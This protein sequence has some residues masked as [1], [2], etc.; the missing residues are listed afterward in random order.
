MVS[1]CFYA[2]LNKIY[3]RHVTARN[4]WV[5]HLLCVISHTKLL[6][7]CLGRDHL[8]ESVGAGHLPLTV[9]LNNLRASSFEVSSAL[10]FLFNSC[11]KTSQYSGLTYKWYRTNLR[12]LWK[13]LW[14]IIPP[15]YPNLKSVRELIYK[16]GHGRMRKQRI[17]LTDNALVEKALGMKVFFLC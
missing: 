2:T 12:S 1:I 15:R 7:R 14:L 10:R 13:P 5:V 4:L 3:F 6:L 9:Y 8:K 11:F 16:R 17:A